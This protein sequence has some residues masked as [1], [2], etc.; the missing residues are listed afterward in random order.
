MVAQNV[1]INW[2]LV[3]VCLVTNIQQTKKE[4]EGEC[5]T[6]PEQIQ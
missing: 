5:A 1:I 2:S 3:V 4:R 6:E